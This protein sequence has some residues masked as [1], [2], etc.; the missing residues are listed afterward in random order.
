MPDKDIYPYH[1]YK[2]ATTV[3]DWMVHALGFE[4]VMVVPG[5]NG[6]VTHAEL[7]FGDRIVMVST[8]GSYPGAISPLDAGGATAGIAL[9][10]EDAELDAHYARAKAS[11]APIY[12]ELETKDYG[13]RSYSLRDPEGGE[14]TIGSYRAGNPANG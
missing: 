11:G 12:L 14:W 13:G 8:A 9:Y 6:S 10:M 3:I 1:Y 4:P 7:R 2:D 5:K